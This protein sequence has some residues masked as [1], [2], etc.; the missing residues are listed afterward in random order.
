MPDN[1]S[2][3]NNV[4]DIPLP[5]VA[6]DKAS[7]LSANL[8]ILSALS[9]RTM[10]PATDFS[11]AEFLATHSKIV[12]SL[13]PNCSGCKIPVFLALNS[14]FLEVAMGAYNDPTVIDLFASGSQLM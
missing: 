5:S 1:F 11:S 13:K 6:G 12:S 9:D 8:A 2:C 3:T 14:K 4:S 10:A 7:L